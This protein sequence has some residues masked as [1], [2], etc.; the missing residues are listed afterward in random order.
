MINFISCE[1]DNEE[2]DENGEKK[3]KVDSITLN[4]KAAEVCKC[5]VEKQDKAVQVPEHGFQDGGQAGMD[6]AHAQHVGFDDA[7]GILYD[8]S[9]L[10]IVV[11]AKKSFN[12]FNCYRAPRII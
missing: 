7:G 1:L 6:T 11:E 4:K 10:T 9:I 3:S 8:A 5:A 2:N 12:H